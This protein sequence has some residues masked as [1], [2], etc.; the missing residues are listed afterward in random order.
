MEPHDLPKG[1]QRAG[2]RP[3]EI[4]EEIKQEKAAAAPASDDNA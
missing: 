4:L 1:A 2:K 3:E